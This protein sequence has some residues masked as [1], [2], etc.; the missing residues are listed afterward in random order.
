LTLFEARLAGCPVIVSDCGSLPDL[1]DARGIVFR[2]GDALDLTRCL[3][4]FADRPR[5]VATTAPHAATVKS[6]AQDAQRMEQLYARLVEAI[7]LAPDR[8]ATGNRHP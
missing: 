7:T 2:S 4:R 6:I 3:A 8:I 1:I 5:L